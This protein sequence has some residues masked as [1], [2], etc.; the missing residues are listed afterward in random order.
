[1]RLIA[2]LATIAVLFAGCAAIFGDRVAGS[3][4]VVTQSR[5]V[6]AFHRIRLNGSAALKIT[7][8]AAQAVQVEAQANIAELIDTKVSDGALVIDNRR[9]YTTNKPVAVHVS[10]P[11]IDGLEING[12]SNVV[13]TG[14]HGSKLAISLSG[15]GSVSAS[16]RVDDLSLDCSGAGKANLAN[17]IARDATISVSGVGSADVDATARLDIS[18]AGLGNVRY[19]GSPVVHQAINGLGHVSRM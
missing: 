7:A 17:L 15:T 14:A 4:D 19:R 2:A 12:F 10:A 6:P 8:G 1:M 13:L 11:S 9:D 16:G 3:G 5:S 18:I